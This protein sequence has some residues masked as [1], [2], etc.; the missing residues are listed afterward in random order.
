MSTQVKAFQWSLLLHCT[1]LAGLVLGG[2]LPTKQSPPLV[3]DFSFNL[4]AARAGES[5][6]A[7]GAEVPAS[8]GSASSQ[9][10]TV[11]T[12]PSIKP[13]KP[14]E[15]A[16]RPKKAILPKPRV[17]K[18]QLLDPPETVKKLASSVSPPPA[19]SSVTPTEGTSPAM[20]KSPV[21][22]AS[23]AGPAQ[24][25]DGAG[26]AGGAL[27][28]QR[29]EGGG[30]RYDFTYVRDRILKNLRFPTTARQ[31]GQRGKIVVSFNLL[32]NGQVE[33][34]AIVASSG[35]ELLDQCVIDT[36]RRVAPFPKPPIRAQLVL[37]IVFRLK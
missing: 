17:P 21:S 15:I 33:H 28:E 20:G 9:P 11:E 29:G 16:A 35:H 12:P 27:G 37:P 3:I 6:T 5:A 14:Q 25:K 1:L 18:K 31:Q 32:A 13:P 7:L 4:T 10:Q 22:S 24:G 8:A 2:L 36:I 26:A 30:M 19:P 34:L 23:G